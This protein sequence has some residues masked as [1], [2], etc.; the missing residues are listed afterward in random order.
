MMVN[1][2]LSSALSK[3]V[4]AHFWNYYINS[5]QALRLLVEHKGY[6]NI[7]YVEGWVVVTFADNFAVP[8]EHAW[9]EADDEIIDVTYYSGHLVHNNVDY[10]VA[11]RYDYDQVTKHF[12]DVGILP[13]TQHRDAN[14]HKAMSASL[15]VVG[16]DLNSYF[17]SKYGKI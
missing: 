2:Q 16:V 1:E 14:N 3:I 6:E 9:L 7:H 10:F 4:V 5:F 17:D 13:I 11:N 12:K 15:S 8:T